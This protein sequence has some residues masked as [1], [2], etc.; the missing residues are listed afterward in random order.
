MNAFSRSWELTKLTFGV[1]R[2]DKELLLFPL[3]SGIFSLAFLIALLFPTIIVEFAREVSPVLG[4]FQYLTLFLA[5]LGLAFIA[6]FFNVCVVF[7]TKTRL[8]GG[9]ATFFDSIRF[10]FSKLHLIFL[11]SLVSATVGLILR[12]LDELAERSG[13]GGELIL[14]IL[15]SILGLLWSIV[16]IFVVP[17]LVYHNLGPFDAIKKSVHVLKKTWGESLIR[18]YGLG[19]VQGVLLLL[20]VLLAVLLGFLAAMVSVY[21]VIAVVV[22]GVLYVLGLILVFSVANSVFNT[23]LFMY[24]DTG[25]V[26]HGFHKDVLQHAFQ[27]KK[28]IIK[29]FV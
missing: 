23:A 4:A 14:A 18:Y 15:N 20:G 25:K 26:P 1:M 19:F 28:S 12:A 27:S 8:E 2:H 6:T 29:G 11:W 5:Y 22:L 17:A 16:T 13:R 7:T 10:A 24:A 21:A 9:D 3:L